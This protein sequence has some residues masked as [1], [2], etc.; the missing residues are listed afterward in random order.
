VRSRESSPPADT[1]NSLETDFISV[2]P[3]IKSKI[4]WSEPVSVSIFWPLT[5][6]VE[7]STTRPCLI[8]K[9]LFTVAIDMTPLTAYFLIAVL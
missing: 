1:S 7:P 5:V 2:S 3:P 8:L 4:Y 9:F 6:A